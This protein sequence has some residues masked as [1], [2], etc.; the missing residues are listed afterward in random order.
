MEQTSTG[1]PLILVAHLFPAIE[2]S[3]VELLRSLTPEEWNAQ[4]MA[5][6]WRV[7][8]VVAHL[9]DTQLRKLSI[10]RDGFIREAP[11][12]AS[13]ADLVAFINRMNPDGVAIYGRLSSS[14]LIS[15][16]EVASRASAEYHVCGRGVPG[17]LGWRTR[18]AQLVRYGV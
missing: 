4:T 13:E 10:A 14:V 2:N 7:R 15:L 17:E 8:D 3:L 1:L 12:I 18:F 5:P 16:M 11:A 9:L 6:K